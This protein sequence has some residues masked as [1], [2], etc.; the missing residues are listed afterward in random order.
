MKGLIVEDDSAKA[1]K[2][3]ELINANFAEVELNLAMSYQ[4]GINEILEVD[5]DFILL[6]MSLPTYDQIKGNFSGKPKGFGGEAILKEMRRYQR[7]S[8]VKVITQYNE[9]DGGLISLHNLNDQLK[10]N[11]PGLY[12]GYIVYIAKRTEWENE[13][14]E[15]LSKIVK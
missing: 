5:Y 2:I 7:K 12:Y 8:I 4:S 15:F 14:I 9:F 13:L 11:Y 6:D 1:S 3:S 10:L